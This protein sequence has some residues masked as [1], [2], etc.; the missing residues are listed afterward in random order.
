MA[1]KSALHNKIHNKQQMRQAKQQ[2][3]DLVSILIVS[4]LDNVQVSFGV[5]M[6]T[7]VG[8]TVVFFHFDP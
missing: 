3:L 5:V 7:T 2:R 1:D 4:S 8:G 6:T